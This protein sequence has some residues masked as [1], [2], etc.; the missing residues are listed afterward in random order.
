LRIGIVNSSSEIGGAE[1]SLLP[2]ARLLA[3][4]HD[5]V[6]FLPGHGRLHEALAAAGVETRP[7]P[8]GKGLA[9]ASRQYG[10]GRSSRIV[11][12]L[13]LQQPRFFML[14][15]E[16]KLD[17]LY[18]NGFRA[19]L[20]A[21][22]PAKLAGVAVAWH[23]RDFV[24]LTVAGRAFAL[25][26]RSADV[27]IAN[28]SAT[29]SQPGLRGAA[30]VIPNGIDLDRFRSRATE[31]EPPPVVG[32][33][34]HL[35]SWK[36]H[37]R[38]LR[39]LRLVRNEMP[40]VRGAIAGAA[41]YDTADHR[42]YA[43]AITNKAVAEGCVIETVPP[44]AMPEWFTRLTVLL[45]CP[46]RPEPFGRALAEAL[47]VGVPVVTRADGGALE[48]VGDAGVLVQGSDDAG[49][50]AAVIELLRS[51][52]RRRTLGTAGVARAHVEFD[53]RRYAEATVRA[54]LSAAAR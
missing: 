45:H 3:A 37:E 51:P 36:G 16:A 5:V 12:E 38:F 42:A 18:C 25:L 23:V 30:L 43:T 7:F 19:Q 9:R 29:A 48:V 41:I 11:A 27:V 20:G 32:M 34:G 14:L 13:L 4:E 40:D 17:V 22:L 2:V 35:T 6:A 44:E 26:Q 50:T 49:L 28:S 52:E 8:L 46:E 47:A 39:V 31:P 53:E 15:R 21:T 54:V 24:P 1:L 10:I 33:V